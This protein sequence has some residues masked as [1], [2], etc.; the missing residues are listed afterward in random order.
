MS[1]SIPIADIMNESD[2]EGLGWNPFALQ[3][4]AQNIV[5]VTSKGE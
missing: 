5:T 4:N 3:N 1:D 2:F